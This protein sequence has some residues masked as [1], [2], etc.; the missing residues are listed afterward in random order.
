MPLSIA[1]PKTAGGKGRGVA[2]ATDMCVDLLLRGNVRPQFRQVE[3]LIEGYELEIGGSGNVFACQMAKLGVA[4]TI[5][6]TAGQD[7]FGDH[8]VARLASEG[9]DVSRVRRTDTMPTGLGVTL[10]EPRDR[11]ILTYL[12]TIDATLPAD[13]PE[14]PDLVCGHWHVASFFLLRSLQHHWPAFL[15]RARERGVTTS[16]DPNWDP[17]DRWQ[18]IAEVLPELDIFLPN[19]AEATAITGE[20]DAVRAARMLAAEGPLVVV[21][22][23]AEGAVAVRGDEVVEI[24]PADFVEAHDV[25]DAVGAGDNFDAGFIRAWMAGRDLRTC[26]N[27]GHRCAAASLSSV[28]GIKSQ[29]SGVI[30]ELE[31]GETT[32]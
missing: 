25:V 12:G 28:G 3:Q 23:G 13:L 27:L 14:R 6:G 17:N 1:M 9:V 21:K 8:L 18:G 15:R 20:P 2:V 24:G 4:T 5:F 10:T 30:P 31:E 26:L 11:A 16:L 7:A 22:R 29:W 32:I 19:D